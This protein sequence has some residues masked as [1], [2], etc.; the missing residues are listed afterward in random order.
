MVNSALGLMASGNLAT[1]HRA[2]VYL[3][4]SQRPDGC[5]PQNFWIDGTAVITSVT[6]DIP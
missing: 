4:C 6:N 5:F 2:L 1:P 3:V